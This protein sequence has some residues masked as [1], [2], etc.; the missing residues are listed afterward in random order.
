MEILQVLTYDLPLFLLPTIRSNIRRGL[1]KWE[2]IYIEKTLETLWSRD[3]VARLLDSSYG[4]Q[5]PGR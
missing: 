3:L 5:D 2:G 1:E 4:K